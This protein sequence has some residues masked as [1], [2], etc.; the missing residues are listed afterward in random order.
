MTN[1]LKKSLLLIATVL[2]ASTYSYATDIVWDFTDRGAQS[3]SNNY[4]Y[5]FLATDGVT[6]MRYT[7]GS[8]DAIVAKSSSQDGYLKENGNT[9]GG[10]AKDVDGTTPISKNR[11]IRLFVSGSG[12]LR[13]NCNSNNVG[14]YKVMD[15]SASGTVLLSSYTANATSSAITVSTSMLW[16]ETSKKGYINNIIWSPSDGSSGDE[17][18]DSQGGG[19]TPTPTPTPSGVGGDEIIKVTLSGNKGADRIVTGSIGGTSAVQN[20]SSSAPYKL[21]SDGAYVSLVLASGYFEATDTL[22][23]TEC[24]KKHA[25][26]YGPAGSGT[27]LLATDNPTDG[28]IRT[29]LT[30]LPANQNSIYVYRKAGSNPTFNGKLTTMA[31]HRGGNP[32]KDATLKSLKYGENPVP[33]F[34]PNNTTYDVELSAGTTTVPTVTAEANNAAATTS[35]TQATAL[36]GTATIT[37][38]SA[39]GTETKTYTINF[40]VAD[41]TPVVQDVTWTNQVGKAVIVSHPTGPMDNGVITGQVKNGTSLTSI[42]PTFTGKNLNIITPSGPADFSNGPVLYSF[43]GQGPIRYY[44]LTI[45]EADPMSSDA[46]LKSLKYNNTSVPGFSSDITTYNIELQAGTSTVPTVTAEKNDTKAADPVISNATG[47]PGTTTITV[48]AEDGTT[49][50]YT[51]NFTVAIPQSTLT[52]HTP[53]VYEDKTNGYGVPLTVFNGNEYETYL[54]SYKSEKLYLGLGGSYVTSSSTPC[55]PGFNGVDPGDLTSEDGWLSIS[56]TKYSGSNTSPKDEFAVSSSSNSTH[57]AEIT[58]S[59]KFSIRI[60][61]YTQFSFAGRDNSASDASKQFVVKINNIEQTFSH[62]STDWTIY[63]FDLNSNQEYVIEVTGK[64]SDPNRLRAFSLRVPKEPRVK[65]FKGNDSTQTVLQTTALQPIVYTTKYNNIPGAETQLEWENGKE[66]TGISMTKKTGSLS[67]TLTLSGNAN[68]ATG[69]YK[70]ALVAYYNGAETNRVTGKFYVKSD[71]K[72][73]S[74]STS[75]EVYQNEE[76]DQIK[77]KYYA[78]SADSVIITW[79]PSTPNGINGTGNNGTYLI[80]G[81]PTQTGEYTYTITVLGADTTITGKINVKPLDYGNNPVLYLYKN[82]LAYEKDGVHKFLKKIGW[83]PIERKA[84]EDGLRP[85]DQY[86]NYRF[87]VI[88]EDV[89]ANNVEALRII[90]ENG[91]NLPVLNLKGFTYAEGR[92]GWGE[93]NNGAIDSA[94]NTKNKGCKLKIM[95]ADHPIF[96]KLGSSA[97]DGS[98]IAVLSNYALQGIMPIAV[99]MHNL[100]SQTLCMGTA[101]TRANTL[102]GYYDEGKW[103]A[104]IH[105]ILPSARGGNKYICLPIARDVTLTT[106]GERLFEGIVDYLVSSDPTTITAPDLLITKFAVT[107]SKNKEYT[108]TIDHTE[109]TITLRLTPEEYQALDSLKAAKPSITHPSYTAVTPASGEEI[110]LTYAHLRPQKYVITDYINKN[111]Y[112]FILELYAP[113]QGIEEAYEAGQWVNIYD[114]YGRKVST[115][116]EDIYTMELPHGMYII[117]TESG[118]TMKIMK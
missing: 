6:E 53:G 101:P 80:G 105:E 26:Y 108:A 91:A 106:A 23:L 118:K 14:Q 98:E 59:N 50:T 88:S 97:K 102:N 79:A 104:A 41:G 48:T 77:F 73:L 15:G 111:V 4:S 11:L 52:L 40:T 86:A 113:Q 20:L 51:I 75:A 83:N 36:P 47:L 31:V 116:N 65:Y 93:P 27:E 18:G 34:S 38:T 61:G 68:C 3:L 56:A 13:I 43:E 25:V 1:T 103:E 71:I 22:I 2:V 42:T 39:D 89:D 44:T 24:D 19:E 46:T 45:T 55:L 67:D 35:A 58:N 72:C 12:T 49:N 82:D 112:D 7:A 78:L 28:V 17:G 90:S 66:A 114:I 64:G 74:S 9:G 33:D 107:D 32:A 94:L 5:S 60:K 37:V 76:M 84:K 69:E 96:A 29:L 117:V 10:S 57:Y 87:V 8:S 109:H 21:N 54:F 100:T 30:G 63:R 81:T 115:T 85:S 16:I 99:D 92:L 62:N 95:H 110:R 70:Y